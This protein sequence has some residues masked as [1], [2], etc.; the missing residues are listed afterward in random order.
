MADNVNKAKSSALPLRLSRLITDR[1]SAD[2]LPLTLY[3]TLGSIDDVELPPV[4]PPDTPDKPKQKRYMQPFSCLSH[5]VSKSYGVN[6][7]YGWQRQTRQQ[8]NDYTARRG[9]TWLIAQ[10]RKLSTLS[11]VHLSRCDKQIIG[12]SLLLQQCQLNQYMALILRDNEHDVCVSNTVHY[13]SCG[14]VSNAKV[15]HYQNCTHHQLDNVV[16]YSACSSHTEAGHH[17]SNCQTSMVQR[18]VQVPCRFYPVAETEVEKP[19]VRVCRIRPPSSRLPLALLRKRT[20]APSSHLPLPLTCWHDVPVATIPNLGAYIMHNKI[21]A[22]IGGISIEPISFNIKTDMDSYCWQGSVEITAHDYD[23]I[24]SKLNV[25]RGNEPLINVTINSTTFTII[26]EE[27]SRSRQFANHSHSLSGRSITAKLGADYAKAQAGLLDQANYA[28]QIINQQLAYLPY[29]VDSFEI[30]D[31]LIPANQYAMTGKTPIAVINE[32]AKA[33]G[34]FIVSDKSDTKLSIKKRWKKAAWELSTAKPDR[35]VPLDV[36]RQI[37]DQKR[38]NPRYNTVMLIGQAEAGIVY[39]QLEGR[40]R[41]APSDDN[42]LYTDQAV[43]IP[44]GIAKLSDS[45]T[46]AEYTIMM[47]WSDKYNVALAELGEIWQIN[48]TEGA[49]R[50]VVTSVS[51]S[52]RLENDAPAI[53]QTVTIDRYLDS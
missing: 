13:K 11:F 22:T 5:T 31:W 43:I 48:D 4:I 45:G 21:T 24:K 17:I 41:E 7:C 16:S 46:H 30:D 3:K 29:T 40:D 23:R 49:W 2:K 6:H 39:R 32:I 20:Q 42:V 26:A 8:A 33:A 34:G 19:S 44:A 52:V 18:A 9:Q 12:Q 27:Q 1:A 50:G 36:I 51:V 15:R 38:S 47:M 10:C 28:S 37:N 35:I 25:E 14:D 53:W